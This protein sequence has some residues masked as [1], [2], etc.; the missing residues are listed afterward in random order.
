[1]QMRAAAAFRAACDDCFRWQGRI[2][3]IHSTKL[4]APAGLDS[5][6]N[7]DKAQNLERAV[8]Q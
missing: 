6:K 7:L 5:A 3:P 1:M 8:R 4:I 2:K